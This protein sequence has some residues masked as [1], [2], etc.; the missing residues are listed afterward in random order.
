MN[1]GG[2]EKEPSGLSYAVSGVDIAEGELAV[3]RIRRS[4][5]ATSI[6]GVLS[7]I[8]GF[9]GLFQLDTAGYREPVLVSSTDG[10]GTKAYLASLARRYST[11][12]IDLVAMC[13]DDIAVLGAKPL[14]LLDY[15]SVGRLESSVAADIVE[16]V[17]AGAR[18]CG[19]AL[20]GGEMAEHPGS[21][22]DGHFDLAGFVV[23]VA[24]K[25]E[26]WGPD[27]VSQGDIV[28]GIDSPNLRSNGFS[29]ARRALFGSL[30][31]PGA[32]AA[33]HE[34]FLELANEP[35]SRPGATIL[36]ELLDPS[37]L[38]SPVLQALAG[39]LEIKAAAHITGGGLVSNLSRALPEGL[40]ASIDFASWEVPGIFRVIQERGGIATGEMRRVFNMGIG[41]A[42]VV[43]PGIAPLV[44]PAL[45]R[46]GRRGF[47][48]GEIVR[49]RRN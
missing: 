47:V 9:G 42:L 20:I 40:T 3:E 2:A 39:E 21:M 38:Y 31:D 24:E 33:D 19:A 41:M 7:S 14:F 43:G 4:V 18:Q 34:R 36:D 16:G 27:R 29:L 45:E 22:P 26:L 6:P 11:I 15:L 12:G 30:S 37:V 44:L 25:S 23:G 13:V 10:V 46:M 35:G 32:S 17:A 28:V 8:G 48:I 5:A 49:E 1:P